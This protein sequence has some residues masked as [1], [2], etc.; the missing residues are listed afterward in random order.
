MGPWRESPGLPSP[1]PPLYNTPTL[2]ISLAE[3]GQEA[4]PTTL[5]TLRFAELGLPVLAGSRTSEV[6]RADNSVRT[7]TL[8]TL[9]VSHADGLAA[10]TLRLVEDG[11]DLAQQVH[12]AYAELLAATARVGC[13]HLL[14]IANYMPAI[15]APD[16]TAAARPR[17]RYHA[18]S[19]GRAR[20]FAQAGVPVPP[21][22]ACA[23][24][25]PAAAAITLA[26]LAAN[27]P[28]QALENPRQVSAYRYPDRYGPQSPSFSRAM[29]TPPGH[30]HRLLLISGTASIVGHES[31]HPGDV[32]AQCDEA[33]ANLHA[34]L[35]ASR[36]AGASPVE[37]A[38]SFRAY[39]RRPSDL[40]LVQAR[41]AAEPNA[42]FLQAEVCRDELLVEIEATY[43]TA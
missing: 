30:G 19:L 9:S 26:C 42:L 8:G 4:G 2:H 41:F 1:A 7:E 27:R 15:T 38:L 12:D 24:G 34:L 39:L 28:G 32:G 23:L 3:P 14:K 20:A 6:W 11:S 25:T 37:P 13:R 16:R 43:A 31:R 33:R 40:A 29:L 10:A 36:A 21:P 18:L 22:A 17:Q 5:G 35:E